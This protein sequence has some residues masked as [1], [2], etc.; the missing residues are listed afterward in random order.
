VLLAVLVLGSGTS[1]AAPIPVPVMILS[2]ALATAGAVAI[3]AAWTGRSWG[4]WL[5][6][7]ASLMTA[8]AA[9]PGAVVASGPLQTLIGAEPTRCTPMR[10]LLRHTIPGKPRRPRARLPI[11]I[12][13][14]AVFAAACQ[15]GA[16]G[17]TATAG[18]SASEAPGSTGTATAEPTSA[19]PI[20][21]PRPT[22][23]PTDG[24]CEQ[25]HV[26]LGLLEPGTTYTTT[27]FAA[28]FSFT[29]PEAGWQNRVDAGH[30]IQLLPIAVPGDVVVFF[31]D[32]R[33][34]DAL[35]QYE[36]GIGSS[37]QDLATWLAANPL[38]DVTPATAVTVGG[39]TGLRMDVRLADKTHNS[40]PTDCP[41]QAC[42]VYF[43]GS[44]PESWSYGVAGSGAQRIYL[45]TRPEGVVAIIVD[46]WDGTTFDTLAE[47]SDAILASVT[48]K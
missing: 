20:D 15:G 9:A 34:T 13:S 6:V 36:A 23:I 31:P 45:L 28:Q 30:T 8:L 17:P 37:V 35:G 21:L 1:I 40:G 48:F 27:E 4:R 29:V 24:S 26:C 41:V 14:L 2:V 10:P 18:P 44:D 7:G 46:S 25:E 32:P 11:M 43:A 33:A 47:A 39:L 38:L 42:L 5:G 16:A 12:A 22:D 19:L 3:V